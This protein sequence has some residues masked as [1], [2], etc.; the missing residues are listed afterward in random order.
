MNERRYKTF[1]K[2]NLTDSNENW[3]EVNDG[4]EGNYNFFRVTV[5][6]P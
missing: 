6:L 1:G 5:D 2:R 3:V 4:E